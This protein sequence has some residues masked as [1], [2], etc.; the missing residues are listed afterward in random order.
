MS[1]DAEQTIFSTK[2]VVLNSVLSIIFFLFMRE[3]LVPHVPSQDP[4]AIMIVSSMTSLCMTGVFWIA[5]NMF[6]VTLVDYNQ[7]KKN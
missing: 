3:V 1:N 2:G 5:A 4:T 6:L 7:K